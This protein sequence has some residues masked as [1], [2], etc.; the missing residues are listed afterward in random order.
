[1]AN[2][3]DRGWADRHENYA[4]G[5]SRTFT[6]TTAENF[7]GVDLSQP[8]VIYSVT[9]TVS[10]NN[11][12]GDFALVDTSATGD[13]G[14]ARLRFTIASGATT[15]RNANGFSVSFPRGM[16]FNDGCVISATNVTGSVTMTY[17]ARYKS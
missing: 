17:K 2:L 8:V 14:T 4:D 7:L 6:V 1:M 12:S 9:L 15:D 10:Q 11:A 16:V 5:F 3:A 13:A